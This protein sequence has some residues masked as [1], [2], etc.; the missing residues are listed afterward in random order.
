VAK[1]RFHDLRRSAVRRLRKLGTA[2]ATAM[3]ITGRL[4]RTVFDACDQANPEDVAQAA[5]IL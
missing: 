2:A 5:E 3:L 1:L 4:S